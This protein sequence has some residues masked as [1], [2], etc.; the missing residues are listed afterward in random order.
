M[1]K[2]ELLR[3]LRNHLRLSEKRSPAWEQNK[4]G[5]AFLWF[6]VII[7]AFYLIMLAIMMSLIVN[8]SESITA[9]EFMYGIL[10]FIT[11]IDFLFRFVFQQTP[12][13]M[14]KPYALLPISKYAC[15]DC[16]LV[17]SL[18]SGYNWVWMLMFIPY[19]I[20]SVVFSEGLFAM[21]GFLLGLL[22]IMLLNSQ[23][24]MLARSLINRH[25]G[26]WGMVLVVYAVIF[27]PCY[28]GKNAGIDTFCDLYAKAGE[29]FTFWNPL[30]YFAVFLAI[31]VLLFINRR[32]QHR[33][34][35]EELGKI[36]TET[37]RGAVQFTA[38]NRMGELGE[39]LKLEIKGILRNKNQRKSFIFSTVLIT[40]LSLL[41]SFTEIYDNPWM[42][43]FWCIY[44]FA[45][46][47]AMG[48]V[49]IMC[50]EG[51]YIDCLMIHQEHII[52]LLRAKY[53]FFTV[54]LLLPFLLML[55]TVFTGKCTLLMLLSYAVFTAGF[56]YFLF[57]QMAVYNK[58]TM[59][60]NTKFIGKGSMEN[61]WLQV[62][63]QMAVF[64]API[65]VISILR[66]LLSETGA[67]LIILLIGLIFITIHQYWI[68]NIYRRM[69][70]RRYENLE[71]FRATRS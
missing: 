25:I 9:Y 29:G 15:I 63:I 32:L 14:V 19:S 70:Q 3:T 50:Y 53:Y 22:L 31:A 58:Q 27:A 59:P 47:G 35:W 60:L 1:K 7:A 55:P 34:V 61:S 28:I 13:Q 44:C 40:A 48:L 57:F 38:F 8:S 21:I 33:I 11:A 10:P 62:G 56:E 24:Y 17:N 12:A 37:V 23:W 66:S 5:K 45:L 51:N 68:R 6:V 46:Y 16:F 39:Y 18:L 2:L 36:E 43:N 41:L 69:M 52:S 64:I 49:K 67:Y 65:I 26:W 4:I 20:M 30:Y 42:T 71:S 54:L